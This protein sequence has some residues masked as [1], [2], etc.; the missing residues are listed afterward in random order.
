MVEYDKTTLYSRALISLVKGPVYQN[1]DSQTWQTIVD[2]RSQ[3]GDY[4]KFIGLDLVI[5]EVDGYAFLRQ[6]DYFDG[7]EPLPRIVPR[8]QLSYSVSLLLVLLRKRLLEFDSASGDG[9]LILSKENIIEMVSIFKK[10]SSNEA[11]SA[12][13]IA[14]D[15]ERVRE[16]GYLKRLT[17]SVEEYE[18]QRIIRSVIDARWM[19]EM[20]D[21]LEEYFQIE[22]DENVDKT[23][24]LSTETGELDDDTE[25]RSE[26]E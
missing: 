6:H 11:A 4:V 22:T 24:G 25:G 13:A 2:Q 18:V 10:D 8:H 3:I 17:G 23:S 16:F 9:R 5:D 14:R 26:Q 19:G 12:D 7:E 15:I 20:N 1:E 21:R